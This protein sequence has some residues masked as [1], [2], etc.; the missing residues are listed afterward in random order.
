[1]NL[2]RWLRRERFERAVTLLFYAD[3]LGR[4]LARA[5]GVP[6]LVT[7]IQARN[8]NYSGWQ[9]WLVRKTMPLADQVVVCTRFLGEYAVQAEGAARESD[10]GDPAWNFYEWQ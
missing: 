8:I 4:P 3:V 7:Y 2:F 5:A 6:R 9:R 1:M 10:P